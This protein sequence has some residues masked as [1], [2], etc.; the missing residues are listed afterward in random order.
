MIARISHEE[1]QRL[2]LLAYENATR[3]MSPHERVKTMFFFQPDIASTV[4]EVTALHIPGMDGPKIA[5]L[6]EQH[7]ASY[8]QMCEQVVAEFGDKPTNVQFG[9]AVVNWVVDILNA[10]CAATA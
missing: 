3:D 4:R 8:V 7:E 2:T 9:T 6:M 1:F 5:T 10:D